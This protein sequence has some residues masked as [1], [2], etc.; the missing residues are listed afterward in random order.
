MTL[1]KKKEIRA[2]TKSDDPLFPPVF[3]K[4]FQN[5]KIHVRFISQKIFFHQRKKKK[6]KS[7][8]LYNTHAREQKKKKK[9]A[10]R[11]TCGFRKIAAFMTRRR[12]TFPRILKIVDGVVV[13]YGQNSGG[14]NVKGIIIGRSEV[15][16]IHSGHQG[17]YMHGSWKILTTNGGVQ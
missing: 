5:L 2:R 8:V 13:R 10:A 15:V 11:V 12:W 3:F 17:T 16:Y 14:S 4:I 7:S 6:K 9:N 1:E